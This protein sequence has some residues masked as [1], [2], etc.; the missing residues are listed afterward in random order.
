MFFAHAK[1]TELSAEN[2]A[3]KTQLYLLKG[4]SQLVPVLVPTSIPTPP[5]PIFSL[6]IPIFMASYVVPSPLPVLLH[7]LLG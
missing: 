1:V 2:A 5:P 7:S 4:T 3:L 6:S